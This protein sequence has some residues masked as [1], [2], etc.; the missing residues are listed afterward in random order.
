[1]FIRPY[2][3]F[4]RKVDSGTICTQSISIFNRINFYHSLQRKSVID[5]RITDKKG[6]THDVRIV[7]WSKTPDEIIGVVINRDDIRAEREI[8]QAIE[9]NTELL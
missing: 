5:T 4:K 9:S 1:M 7:T 8:N 6:R 3:H 2:G